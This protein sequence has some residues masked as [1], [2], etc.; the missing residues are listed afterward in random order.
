MGKTVS[1]IAPFFGNFI[2]DQLR[3]GGS[4]FL[5]DLSRVAD[6]SFDKAALPQERR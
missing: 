3:R 4:Y 2:C 6:F 1:A 5:F